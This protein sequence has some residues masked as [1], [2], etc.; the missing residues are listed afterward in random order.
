MLN[1]TKK[2]G[3]VWIDGTTSVSQKRSEDIDAGRGDRQSGRLLKRWRKDWRLQ[4]TAGDGLT[5]LVRSWA[6]WLLR[7]YSI[8]KTKVICS[9]PNHTA[10][11]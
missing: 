8:L 7:Y 6:S 1:I 11:K 9:S 10:G 2:T 4:R 5:R 3:G